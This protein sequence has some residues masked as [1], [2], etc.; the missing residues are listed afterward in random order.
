MKESGGSVSVLHGKEPGTPEAA[1]FLLPVRLHI[2]A[3]L[4]DDM[5]PKLREAGA[6]GRQRGEPGQLVASS[7]KLKS[8]LI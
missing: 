6:N 1:S 5:R 7:L 2:L 3:A 8:Q 4:P